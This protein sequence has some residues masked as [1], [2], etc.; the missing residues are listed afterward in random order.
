MYSISTHKTLIP[1]LGD[2]WHV[3]GL[4]RQMDFCYVN[5]STVEVYIYKRRPVL[6]FTPDGQQTID[7]GCVLIFKFVRMDGMRAEWNTIFEH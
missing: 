4:N 3:R 2:N 6:D 5:I 7:R 1:L